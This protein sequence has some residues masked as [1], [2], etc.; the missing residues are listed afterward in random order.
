MFYEFN[1]LGSPD[2]LK[3]ENGKDFNYRT[4]LHRCFEIIIILSG[5]MEVTIDEKTYLLKKNNAVLIFPNQLHSLSSKKSEHI[6]CIFSPDLVKAYSNKTFSLLPDS[7]IFHPNIYLIN[8]LKNINNH[9]GICEKK[10]LFYSFCAEFDKNAIYNEKKYF[11]DKLLYKMF[12]FVEDNFSYEC[13]LEKLAN[14]IGYNYSYLSRFFKNTVKISFNNYVTNYRLSHACYLLDNTDSSIIN[15]AVESGFDSIRTFNRN[16]KT[17]YGI[18]PEEYRKS[19][20]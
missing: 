17:L 11:K 16:F 6:L 1:H 7:N 20:T 10:G 19:K 14:Q 9:S 18:T 15:C 4:H 5:E 13:T 12:A 8:S 2:Y 3:I